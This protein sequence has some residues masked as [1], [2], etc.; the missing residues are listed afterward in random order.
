MRPN[1]PWLR[2]TSKRELDERREEAKREADI[3]KMKDLAGETYMGK[4]E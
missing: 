2:G 1:H 3:R 4:N